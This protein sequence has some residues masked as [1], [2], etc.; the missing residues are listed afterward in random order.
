MQVHI[1]DYPIK[2]A[3]I[4]LIL[5]KII[6]FKMGTIDF[7]RSKYCKR[8]ACMVINIIL[9]FILPWIIALYIVRERKI[10][11]YIAPFASVVS[12]IFDDLGFYYFWRIYPFE[13]MNLSGLPFNIGLF[14]LYPCITIQ[15]IRKHKIS[16]FPGL[17][18]TGLVI[19]LM[20][21]CGWLIGRIVY[22]NLWNIIETF[23][24]YFVQ[25]LITYTFYK[26]LGKHKL[27]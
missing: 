3:V 14:A 2:T 4:G 19:T 16:D 11:Y 8:G 10:L 13:L 15:L 17:L 12:F 21:L 23:F 9:G 20:E 22:Y 18:I 7:V 6:N 5:L 27:V 24:S 1:T 25:L 26:L